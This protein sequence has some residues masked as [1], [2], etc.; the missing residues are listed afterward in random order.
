M[1]IR[2]LLRSFPSNAAVAVPAPPEQRSRRPDAAMDVMGITVL[3]LG[4]NE[5]LL[6]AEALVTKPGSGRELAFLD[7]RT[8]LRQLIDK[9]CRARLRDQVLFPAG[10]L[11]RLTARLTKRE[12]PAVFSGAAF[13]PALLTFM[14]RPLNIVVIGADETAARA[15]G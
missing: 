7:G 4:W 10:R 14:E 6:E 9:K 11:L 15:L 1:R 3:A 13:V 8:V 2:A 12:I 5:A